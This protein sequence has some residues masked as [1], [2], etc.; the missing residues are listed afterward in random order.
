MIMISYAVLIF[1]QI[2]PDTVG[3]DNEHIMCR[4]YEGEAC[5]NGL[6]AAPDFKGIIVMGGNE[7]YRSYECWE[8]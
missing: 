1:A 8:V 7:Q 6:N 5:E 2:D 3:K 4:V